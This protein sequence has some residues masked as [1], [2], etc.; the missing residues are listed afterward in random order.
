[1]GLECKTYALWLRRKG[2]RP[3]FMIHDL[4]PLTNPEYCRRGERARHQVRMCTAISTGCGIITN[5]R[6][7]L[8]GLDT[9]AKS[10]QLSLPATLVAPLASGLQGMSKEVQPVQSPY[11]VVLGTIEPRKNHWMLLQTWRHV[12][13]LMGTA[14]PRLVIIGQRGWEC[15]NVEDLLERCESLRGVVFEYSR[16][17]DAQLTTCLR[18][19][20]ALLFPSLV[21]GYGLPLVEALTLGVPA[22]ASS[23][24]V[25]REFAGDI[26]DY[27]DPLDGKGWRELIIEYTNPNSGKRAAQ[28]QRMTGFQAPTWT[29]HMADVDA[30]LQRLDER[31]PARPVE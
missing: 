6:D 27:L 8:A 13:D 14:A 25:F 30:F 9:F 29:R 3:I 21:E 11:F 4:I 17:S 16:C 23:L 10:N 20:Q 15:E 1:M 28:L 22:I 24:E 26:P 2:V 19:S 7:T 12:I 5:S 18:Q 31:A